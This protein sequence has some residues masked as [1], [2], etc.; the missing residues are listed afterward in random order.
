MMESNSTALTLGK[1]YLE[2]MEYCFKES[3]RLSLTRRYAKESTALDENTP[4][5][6]D[7]AL[8]VVIRFHR[9][10][11]Q[12]YHDIDEF[13]S[14]PEL[15]KCRRFIYRMQSW[16]CYERSRSINEWTESSRVN[17]FGIE[18]PSVLAIIDGSYHKETQIEVFLRNINMQ[19]TGG[20]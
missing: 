14:I 20:E 12:Q 5:W 10:I 8:L 16:I 6:Y 9:E 7:G 1:I 2:C 11:I 13:S 4:L 19:I 17:K 3:D 15:E 18:N